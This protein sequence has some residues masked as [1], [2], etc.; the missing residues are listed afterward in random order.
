MP[1]FKLPRR[2]LL[3][4]NPRAV[5]KQILREAPKTPFEED[6]TTRPLDAWDQGFAQRAAVD[7]FETENIRLPGQPSADPDMPSDVTELS[8]QEL[9]TLYAQFVAYTEFLESKAALAEITSE[10]DAAYHLHIEAEV[11]LSKS[12]TVQD[13]AAKT[14]QDPKYIESEIRAISSKAKAKLLRAR[15]KGYE[16]CGNAL[17]REMTRRTPQPE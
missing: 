15:A 1:V 11:R 2:T 13:K 5:A 14:L 3:K 12:G 6:N 8:S 16:R 17:S 4:N 10:E 7:Y 9:G